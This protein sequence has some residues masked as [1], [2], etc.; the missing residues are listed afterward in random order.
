M[1]DLGRGWKKWD[2]LLNVI[3]LMKPSNELLLNLFITRVSIN[4]G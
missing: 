3:A 1:N 4:N 2:A